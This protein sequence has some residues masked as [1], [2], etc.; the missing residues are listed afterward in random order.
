MRLLLMNGANKRIRLPYHL[1]IFLPNTKFIIKTNTYQ[2][3]IKY[4][5]LN[6]F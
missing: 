6:V 4:E 3:N 1:A 2:K 5:N